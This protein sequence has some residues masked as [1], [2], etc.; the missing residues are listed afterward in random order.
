[1]NIDDTWDAHQHV[2]RTRIA[3][4]NNS[5]IRLDP[6]TLIADRMIPAV[7]AKMHHLKRSHYLIQLFDQTMPEMRNANL[8][9]LRYKTKSIRKI[10]SLKS[11]TYSIDII[12]GCLMPIS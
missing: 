5:H 3:R 7:I 1:M 6:P 4:S 8:A 9:L 2:A 11:S 12:L 10:C